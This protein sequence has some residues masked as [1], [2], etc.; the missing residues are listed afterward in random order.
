[1]GR[2]VG[3]WGLGKC[4]GRCEELEGTAIAGFLRRMS[5]VL[6]VRILFLSSSTSLRGGTQCR[7]GRRAGR[8][9]NF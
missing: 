3:T 9:R 2:R 7:A 1:M 6:A 4:M 5:V 8:Q